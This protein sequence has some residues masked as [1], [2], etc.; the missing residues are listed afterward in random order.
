M[1]VS[2]R[3]FP[4]K[5]HTYPTSVGCFRTDQGSEIVPWKHVSQKPSQVAL[6]GIPRCGQH[7]L[8]G[9]PGAMNPFLVLKNFPNPNP[10]NRD[11]ENTSIFP[12]LGDQQKQ[13]IQEKT[14]FSQSYSAFFGDNPF[15]AK[16][17]PSQMLCRKKTRKIQG[18]H[19][20]THTHL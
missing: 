16:K 5:W 9:D 11:S 13:G 12:P 3:V 1:L 7:V 10:K 17:I 8:F 19:T 15:S 2:G 14:H 18:K 20:H 4:E 6:G